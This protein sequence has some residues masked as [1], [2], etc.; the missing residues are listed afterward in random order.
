MTGPCYLLTPFLFEIF[1]CF[2]KF[3]NM[4]NYETHFLIILYSFSLYFFIF[5]MSAVQCII[6]SRLKTVQAFCVYINSVNLSDN[7]YAILGYNFTYVESIYKYIST[8]FSMCYIFYFTLFILF[9]LAFEF[10]YLVYPSVKSVIYST[11]KLSLFKLCF[12]L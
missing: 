6:F 2:Q 12:Q 9:L 1:L 8:L 10:I 5:S 11:W 4:L 7:P 3:G